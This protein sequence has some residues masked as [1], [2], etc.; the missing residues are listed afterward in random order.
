MKDFGILH[1]FRGL[2]VWQKPDGIFLNQ[3]KYTADILKRFGMLNC[4]PMCTLMETNLHKLK[5]ATS[6]SKFADPTL[7]RQIIGSL[8]VFG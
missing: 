6:K 1:Y 2:E 3:G 5:E 7:Y 8:N 4:R